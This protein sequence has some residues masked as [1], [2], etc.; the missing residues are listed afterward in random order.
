MNIHHSRS[1]KRAVIA[2]LSLGAMISAFVK[3][4]IAQQTNPQDP[5]PY[6]EN[7]YDSMGGSTFGNSFNPLDLI[8]RANLSTGRNTEEFSEESQQNLNNAADQFKRQQQERLNQQS[9]PANER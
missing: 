1:A 8:H 7:E 6:Q 9:S 3:P 2:S 4:A 5:S